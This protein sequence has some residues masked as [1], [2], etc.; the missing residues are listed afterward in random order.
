MM[1]R[2]FLSLA[3]VLF[4]T[5]SSGYAA[6]ELESKDSFAADYKALRKRFIELKAEPDRDQVAALVE[7][8]RKLIKRSDG[9][10]SAWSALVAVNA[11]LGDQEHEAILR[12]ALALKGPG[13]GYVIAQ[14]KEQLWRFDHVGHPL[15]LKFEAHDGREVDLQK[16]KGKVVLIYFCAGWCPPCRKIAPVVK[17]VYEKFHGQG[18]EVIGMSF[19][20]TEKEFLDYT[21]AQAFPWP[22]QFNEK[23]NQEFATKNFIRGLPTGWLIDKKGN[24]IDITALEDLEAKVK[25]RLAE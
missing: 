15:E 24:L 17:G 18:F 21:K 20:L 12:E 19:E 2:F 6:P 7:D 5:V 9:E 10:E 3:T 22:Q 13:Y 16:M 4:V 23:W 11:L 8:V 25:K 14:A 1:P